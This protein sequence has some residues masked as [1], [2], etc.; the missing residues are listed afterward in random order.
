LLRVVNRVPGFVVWGRVLLLAFAAAALVSGVVQALPGRAVAATNRQYV[1]P[2]H[3]GIVSSAPGECPICHM[4]LVPGRAPSEEK[5]THGGEIT[6][7]VERRMVAAQ[8]RAAA[9]VAADGEGTAVLYVDDLVGLG[10]R[11]PARFFGAASPNMGIA[12]HL[13]LEPPPSPIDSS[14]VR[15]GFRLDDPAQ[16]AAPVGTSQDVG[17]LQ[18]EARARPLLVVPRSA[19]LYSTQGP[20]VLAASSHDQG[21]RMLEQSESSDATPNGVRMLEQSESSDARPQNFAKRSVRVGRTL[22]SGYVGGLAGTEQGA[23]AILAGLTDGEQV[24]TG[25]TFFVDAERRLQQTSSGA[26]GQGP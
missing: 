7:P 13:R 20:Y 4:A 1:C 3:P 24:V 9:S 5:A 6:A 19:V 14:T 21:V 25:Y 16:R 15:V 22:D 17:S 2:M 12:A 8:V 26:G 23:V 18:I 11:E 10:P